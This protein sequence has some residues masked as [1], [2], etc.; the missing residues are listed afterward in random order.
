MA[1]AQTEAAA[2]Q[3]E[4]RLGHPLPF[5]PDLMVRCR[6][7]VVARILGGERIPWD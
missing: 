1:T 5:A 4:A 3:L 7:G 2:P 6:E